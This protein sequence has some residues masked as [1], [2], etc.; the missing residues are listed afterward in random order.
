MVRQRLVH[1]SP[2]E[3]ES[4]LTVSMR[5]GRN[6]CFSRPTNVG[7]T[8]VFSPQQLKSGVTLNAWRQQLRQIEFFQRESNASR[9]RVA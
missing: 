1:V 4:V 9:L 8:Q 2:L 7:G 5:R 3:K 6:K